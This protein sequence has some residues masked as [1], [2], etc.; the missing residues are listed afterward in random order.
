MIK[1]N[2]IVG[3]EL[4]RSHAVAC[5]N[6]GEYGEVKTVTYGGSQRIRISSQCRKRAER[7]AMHESLGVGRG[8]R[9]AELGQLLAKRLPLAAEQSDFLGK[10]IV[11]T[12][13]GQKLEKENANT[14][15]FIS[16]P[17]LDAIAKLFDD[18]ARRNALFGHYTAKLKNHEETEAA[19]KAKRDADKKAKADAKAGKTV[20]F[21]EPGSVV[22]PPPVE[23]FDDR[24][25]N[26]IKGEILAEM[27]S[28]SLGWDVAL[29]GR[30]TANAKASSVDSALSVAHA[31]TVHEAQPEADYFSALDDLQRKDESGSAHIN[32]AEFGSGTFYSYAALD[33]FQL[34]KNL[35]KIPSEALTEPLT[36]SQHKDLTDIIQAWLKAAIF[37]LPKARRNSMNA[38]S[39]PDYVRVTI[40]QNGIPVNHA[41]AFEHFRTNGESVTKKA[42]EKLE[43]SA[44]R[45]EKYFGIKPAASWTINPGSDPESKSK[46]ESESNPESK[47]KPESEPIITVDDALT[48]VAAFLAKEIKVAK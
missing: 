17:E 43:Q 25:F 35:F 39:L 4:L 31:F 8:Y 36:I 26:S 40:T 20:P 42:I 45:A 23:A 19:K 7:E 44:K 32:E 3:L 10:L 2:L 1:S 12:L 15:L 9:T 18:A 13:S 24:V 34:I 30:M 6:R 37:A 48:G 38:D 29:H 11:H 16:D 47:S 41:S 27:Q 5:L 22:E 21:V 28:A 14:L 33:V 46:P